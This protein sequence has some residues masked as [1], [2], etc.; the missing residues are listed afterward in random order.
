MKPFSFFHLKG[1]GGQIAALVLASTVALH[2]VITTAFLI[3]RQDRP[4]APPDRAHQLAD[5]ALLLEAAEASERPRLVTDLARA[6]P[7]LGI[8]M[9][10][11]GTANLA[12]SD[13]LHLRWMRRHLGRAYK[14][15]RLASGSIEP[16]IGVQLPD[17][18]VIAGHVDGA[19][20]P[21]FSGAPWLMA[22][23]SAFI[24]V[25]VLGLWAARALTRPLS[26]FAAA[27]ENFSLEGAAEPLPE[28]GPEEIRAVARAL[29][30]MHERIV[31]LMSDRTRM[32][33]AISHDLRT[34]ITRLR[35]RAEFIEDE[36]NRKRMLMD[37]DQMRAMLESV[38]SLL[39]D[40]RK[41][42]AVTLV[43]IASTLQ[44]VADQFGDMG[45]VVHYVG[46]AS[47]TAAARPDDLHRGVTNLVE[48][49]VRF[50][51]D[52]TIR[53]DVSDT[54]LVIDVED[55][56]PGIS[57]ARKQEMLEPFVRGDDAR[58]MDYST[59]FGLGL[60]IARAIALG[61]GGELSLHDRAPRGLIVR[62]R[63]PVSQAPRLAA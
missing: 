21:L 31:R 17:G 44:L 45:Q 48:N 1:I 16:R 58:T 39:R 55:D 57:D 42:E 62:M 53:L 20:R 13:S 24:C 41:V 22:L 32:L 5:A 56:G 6:F 59:G 14:T 25:T 10:A 51:A 29:N 52:V 11:P 33:A 27:A 34:P 19:P 50:G 18:T 12:E 26:S 38:L 9:L 47:A 4:D 60:S 7:G 43:D 54:M 49:A 40:D 3:I 36:S 28:R 46:P 37:L 15:G 30:R 23:M 8:E 2:L 61:H 35:L 63:L